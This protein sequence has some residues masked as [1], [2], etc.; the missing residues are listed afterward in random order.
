M[1]AL[2]SLLRKIISVIL[3]TSGEQ[4]TNTNEHNEPEVSFNFLLSGPTPW[5][6]S[7]VPVLSRLPHVRRPRMRGAQLVQLATLVLVIRGEL[8]VLRAVAARDLH[9]VRPGRPRMRGAQLAR[10]AVLILEPMLAGCGIK[11]ALL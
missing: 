5:F 4:S 3:R 1:K 9:R 11:P 8:R 6:V 7:S 10:F 2:I